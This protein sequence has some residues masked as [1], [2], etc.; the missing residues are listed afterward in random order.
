MKV[1]DQHIFQST[2]IIFHFIQKYLPYSFEQMFRFNHDIPNS[3]AT[4]QSELLYEIKCKTNFDNKSPLYAIPKMWKELFHTLP[5]NM[6][7]SQIKYV[8]K[9]IIISSYQ[10]QIT[11]NNSFCLDCYLQASQA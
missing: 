1:T 10:S 4:T 6:P 2:L 3:R 7:R 8:M 5:Q 11:Y 9:E